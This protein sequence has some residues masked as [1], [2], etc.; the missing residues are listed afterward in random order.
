MALKKK[1][2]VVIK[3]MV[4]KVPE[5]Y[6]IPQ[7][8]DDTVGLRDLT[9]QFEKT[10]AVSPMEGSYTKDVLNVPDV[11]IKQDVELVYDPFRVEKKMTVEEERYIDTN[12]GDLVKS[13]EKQLEDVSDQEVDDYI[14]SQGLE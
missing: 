11:D 13:I 5:A 14:V 7:I 12:V 3:H 2:E 10:I 6:V 9:H 8:I 1:Q 4:E